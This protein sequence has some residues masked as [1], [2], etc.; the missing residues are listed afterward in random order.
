MNKKRI[1]RSISWQSVFAVVPILSIWAAYRIKKLRKFLLLHLIL[2]GINLL[3]AFL[4]PF[5]H[6][7]PVFL[8]IYISVMISYMRRWSRLWNEDMYELYTD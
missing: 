7:M 8:A 4:I 3:V 5:P 6:G 1:E 2:V